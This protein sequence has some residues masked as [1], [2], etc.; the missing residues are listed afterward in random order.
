MRRIL[1]I[2]FILS[3][4]VTLGQ[5]NDSLRVIY[6]DNK[7][8]EIVK[9]FYPMI[10]KR[11]KGEIYSVSIREDSA[12]M[13]IQDE[14]GVL[15][16]G[17]VKVY[18][19]FYQLIQYLQYRDSALTLYEFYDNGI[20]RSQQLNLKGDSVF[21]LT[22]Y[23][24]DGKPQHQEYISPDSLQRTEWYQN[25]NIR[26]SCTLTD[27]KKETQREDCYYWNEQGLFE[28]GERNILNSKN[29]Y[30]SN[31][32]IQVYKLDKNGEIIE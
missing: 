3:T 27:I 2:I 1:I 13:T 18:N 6:Q 14:Y 17:E 29:K 16:D 20:K 12:A 10:E 31:E 28:N 8:I 30:L 9:P 23:Y 11:L 15:E 24:S 19:R 5:D 32:S 22:L 21:S 7:T 26:L 4:V 25:G